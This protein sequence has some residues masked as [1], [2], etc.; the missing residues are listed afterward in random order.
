MKTLVTKKTKHGVYP[1]KSFVMN[2]SFILIQQLQENYQHWSRSLDCTVSLFHSFLPPPSLR[3]LL[4][5]P[6]REERVG[7]V[8]CL[9]ESGGHFEFLEV[10]TERKFKQFVQDSLIGEWVQQTCAVY[11]FVVLLTLISLL[12]SSITNF[13]TRNKQEAEPFLNMQKIDADHSPHQTTPFRHPWSN[14]TQE[15]LHHT[16]SVTEQSSSCRR[17]KWLRT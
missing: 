17:M 13:P 12:S 15:F 8:G 9:W 4:G 10:V 7:K 1:C 11:V 2:L 5:E 14:K 3:L 6:T 16:D